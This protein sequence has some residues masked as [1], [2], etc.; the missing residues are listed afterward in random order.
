MRWR[1]GGDGVGVWPR[2]AYASDSELGG[3]VRLRNREPR[4]LG[5]RGGRRGRRRGPRSIF[6]PGRQLGLPARGATGDNF[7][8]QALTLE[9]RV[10]FWCGFGWVSLAKRGGS[11]KGARGGIPNSGQAAQDLMWVVRN[12]GPD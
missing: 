5:S 8:L 12:L 3:S 11:P 6:S 4:A 9:A 2:G 10:F 7:S 1:G